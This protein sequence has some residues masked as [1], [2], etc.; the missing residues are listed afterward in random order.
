[1]NIFEGIDLDAAWNRGYAHGRKEH[2]I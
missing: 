2:Y 1:L